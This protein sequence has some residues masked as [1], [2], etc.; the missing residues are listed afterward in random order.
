MVQYMLEH[1]EDEQFNNILQKL[2]KHA[3]MELAGMRPIRS[4]SVNAGESLGASRKLSG[5]QHEPRFWSDLLPWSDAT[6]AEVA[7]QTEAGGEV[8]PTEADLPLDL[9]QTQCSG[10]GQEGR[11]ATAH[12]NMLNDAKSLD[13]RIGCNESPCGEAAELSHVAEESATQSA[14][15]SLEGSRAPLVSDKS[16]VTKVVTN[17][18]SETQPAGTHDCTVPTVAQCTSVHP[19]S[20]GP[21]APSAHQPLP[22][23]SRQSEYVTAHWWHDHG[24]IPFNKFTNISI[25]IARAESTRSLVQAQ[26]RQE[27]LAS[28]ESQGPELVLI[29]LPAQRGLL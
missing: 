6:F 3:F 13:V 2:Y 18:S 12:T 29:Y 5:E 28:L 8:S 26:H 9:E 14:E 17:C 10:L 25:W 19:T 27:A 11:N 7:V 24:R 21:L 16:M 15:Q 20:V 1:C 4:E 22:S 23:L